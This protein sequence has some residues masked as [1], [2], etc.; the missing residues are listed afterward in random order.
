MGINEW[1]AG[2]AAIDGRIRL[3]GFVDESR[4]AG[5]HRATDC[6][7]N[8]GGQGTLETEGVADGQNLLADLERGGIAQ[9]QRGE[10]LALRIDFHDGDVVALV[11]ADEFSGIARLIAEDHLDG[12]R[13]L[14]N[15]IIRQNVAVS[16]EDEAGACACHG[17]GILEEIIFRGLG[18]DIGDGG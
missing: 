15:V 10:L 16:V 4:L 17:N 18:Q 8:A 7:D 11:R 1:P 14:H 6:A 12:L 13:A 2:V 5:L 3:N 9:R